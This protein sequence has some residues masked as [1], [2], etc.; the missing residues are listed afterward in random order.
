MVFLVIFRLLRSVPSWTFS[1]LALVIKLKVFKPDAIALV[2]RHGW[3]N[4]YHAK[5]LGRLHV[6]ITAIKRIGQHGFRRQTLLLS[7][8]N[9]WQ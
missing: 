6:F 3:R 5:D 2:P 7:V 4:N 8:L 9:G 1:G